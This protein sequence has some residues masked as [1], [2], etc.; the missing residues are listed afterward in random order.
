M[1][2]PDFGLRTGKTSRPSVSAPRCSAWRTAPRGQGVWL[3]RAACLVRASV[4]RGS[5]G[6]RA[7]RGLARAVAEPESE[8]GALGSGSHTAS[9]RSLLGLEKNRDEIGKIKLFIIFI[10]LVLERSLNFPLHRK[11]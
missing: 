2:R 10:R 8:P 5:L 6:G 1:W 9:R 3:E 4:L 7:G 11:N